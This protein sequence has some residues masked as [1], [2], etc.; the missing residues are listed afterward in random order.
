MA[1]V[2]RHGRE[3]VT[4]DDEA[5]ER[6]PAVMCPVCG[7]TMTHHA[8]K[9]VASVPAVDGATVLSAL[10]CPNCGAQQ[11]MVTSVTG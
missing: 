1:K 4:V 11:G 7:T 3:H 10:S 9:E 2:L 5:A 6:P 8:D